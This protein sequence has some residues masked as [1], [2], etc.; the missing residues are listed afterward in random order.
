VLTEGLEAVLE[1]RTGHEL[2]LRFGVRLDRLNR[3]QE[4]KRLAFVDRKSRR[5]LIV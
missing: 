3:G 4:R 5:V 1:R 2:D